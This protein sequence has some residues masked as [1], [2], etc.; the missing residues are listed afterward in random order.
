MLIDKTIEQYANSLRRMGAFT[1]DDINEIKDHMRDSIDALV[2]EGLEENE[3]ILVAKRRMGTPED[4]SFEYAK[5]NRLEMIISRLGWFFS[6]IV[7]YVVMS[8]LSLVL[9]YQIIKFLVQKALPENLSIV[10]FLFI[11]LFMPAAAFWLFFASLLPKIKTLL[12]KIP[13]IVQILIV[14]LII[15]VV[16]MS[17]MLNFYGLDN[18]YHFL[19]MFKYNLLTEYI[20]TAKWG[21]GFIT[22]VLLS[23]IYLLAR[24]NMKKKA[25]NRICKYRY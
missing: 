10:I 2:S 9:S 6:G 14:S 18:I 3:A 16:V 13:L 24:M 5:V 8:S 19:R 17:T 11:Y 21:Y 4:V 15:S 25:E 7:F 22:V 1:D 20:Y 12:T 23:V